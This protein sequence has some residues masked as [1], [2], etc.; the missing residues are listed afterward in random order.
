MS[1]VR[2]QTAGVAGAGTSDMVMPGTA[3]AGLTS[4]MHRPAADSASVFKVPSLAPAHSQTQ[5]RHDTAAPQ[6]SQ[7]DILEH[8]KSLG[9]S[10]VAVCIC[11][12]YYI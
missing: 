11:N 5:F 9:V 7:H 1:A 10:F 3:G 8:I 2:E 12:L 4:L 6:P